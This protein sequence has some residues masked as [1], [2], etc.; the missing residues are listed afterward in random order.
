VNLWNHTLCTSCYEAEE[1]GC[2]PVRMRERESLPCCRCGA[3]SE[4]GIF[5][6]AA[7]T[8]FQCQA[9]TGIHELTE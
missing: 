7:P 1:P 8:H 2:E 9:K 6:R 5:Y 4:S 3:P